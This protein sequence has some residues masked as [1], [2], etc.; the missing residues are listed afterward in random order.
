MPAA[1]PPRTSALSGHVAEGAYGTGGGATPGVI[2]AERRGA[3]LAQINGAG[4][5]AGLAALCQ[6]L[7]LPAP[8][9]PRRAST[10][11]GVTLMWIGPGM[12]LAE[13]SRLEPR[14]LLSLLR[15]ALA[16]TAATVT[17]LSHGRTCIA[18]TGHGIRQLLAK[19][20]PLDAEALTAG[21]CV[22]TRIAQFGV[23]VHLCA[24]DAMD[25]FVARSFGLSFWQWL[26]DAAADLGYQ[27]RAVAAR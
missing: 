2:L 16:G 11:N 12:W 13:A 1:E 19:G 22:V 26:G 20:C 21:D 4:E 8:P 3:A 5:P 18:M 15:D 6:T 10:G 7:A 27:V 9:A 24:D 25:V 17:D 23:V 14:A